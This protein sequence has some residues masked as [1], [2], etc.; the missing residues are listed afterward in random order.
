VVYRGLISVYT[1]IPVLFVENKSWNPET[2]AEYYCR[3]IF[4]FK[5]R[6][7]IPLWSAAVHL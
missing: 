1:A 4:R 2:T 6:R 5:H 3:F 7:D